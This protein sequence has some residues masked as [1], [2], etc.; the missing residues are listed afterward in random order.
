[1]GIWTH[2][3]C[4]ITYQTYTKKNK[5]TGKVYTT[6][7]TSG[8]GTPF[9]NIANRDRNHHMNKAGFGKARFDKSSKNKDAIRG[10]EQLLIEKY[11]GAQS[12][13][14]TSGNKINGISD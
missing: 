8:T 3:S 4:K 9:Q 10:R 2:N 6:G 5:K 7:R 14:G 12:K 1:M 11:G 13:G